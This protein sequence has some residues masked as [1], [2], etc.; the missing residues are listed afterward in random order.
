[1]LPQ[2]ERCSEYE[3]AEG[4][5]E[6]AHAHETPHALA[7]SDGYLTW[8]ASKSQLWSRDTPPGWL[9]QLPWASGFLPTMPTRHENLAHVH[10][11]RRT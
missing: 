9:T 6:L 7:V 1:V 5:C 11:E 4:R 8:D 2:P 10:E 3:T